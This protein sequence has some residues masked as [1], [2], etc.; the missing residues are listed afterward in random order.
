MM[1]E[2]TSGLI[3]ILYFASKLRPF[4]FSHYALDLF[5]DHCSHT[6]SHVSFRFSI[7]IFFWVRFDVL[8]SSENFGLYC[9][10]LILHFA[11]L[12]FLFLGLC[13]LIGKCG[14]NGEKSSFFIFFFVKKK[15]I[16]S[17]FFISVFFLEC[18]F[19]YS[20][21]STKSVPCSFCSCYNVFIFL[22]EQPS[23][24]LLTSL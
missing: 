3:V 22:S 17:L 9:W 15:R 8:V 2:T 4:S 6:H 18:G 11:S 21:F 7:S 13:F 23:F 20:W 5:L 24:S 19:C 14:E 10:I 12:L 16:W 1:K